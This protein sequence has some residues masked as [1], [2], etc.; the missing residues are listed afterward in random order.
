M[1]YLTQPAAFVHEVLPVAEEVMREL[2]E[3]PDA[4][5]VTV[6]GEQPFA[7]GASTMFAT[8]SAFRTRLATMAS[9]RSKAGVLSR[10]PAMTLAEPRTIGAARLR[11]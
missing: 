10:S 2:G 4:F 1:L 8:W 11:V 5:E 3:E 9:R 6:N 7:S